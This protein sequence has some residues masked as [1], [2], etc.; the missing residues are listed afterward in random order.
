MLYVAPL[1]NRSGFVTNWISSMITDIYDN[2]SMKN[3][4]Y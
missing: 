1:E 4:R 2:T 3:M